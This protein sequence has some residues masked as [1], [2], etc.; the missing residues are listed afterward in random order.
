MVGDSWLLVALKE[1]RFKEENKEMN[2]DS[3]IFSDKKSDTL[4]FIFIC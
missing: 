4:L 3:I 2:P 1:A